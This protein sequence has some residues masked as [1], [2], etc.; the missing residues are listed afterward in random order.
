MGFSA[1]EPQTSN[2]SALFKKLKGIIY[3]RPTLTSAVGW[4]ITPII[5]GLAFGGW[6]EEYFRRPHYM[7]V[8]VVVMMVAG[9]IAYFNRSAIYAEFR[10]IP[11]RLR[12]LEW[13]W[14]LVFVAIGLRFLFLQVVPPEFPGFEE[15]QQGKI[16]NDIVNQNASLSFHFL[17]SNSLAAL[18]FW[19]RGNELA[20]L[21]W[22]FEIAGA[23]SILLMA[24]CLRQFGMGWPATL[25]V[26]FIM[27]TLRW[28]V[29]VGG[30]A[31]ETFGPAILLTLMLLLMV[32]SD[33][34]SSFGRLWAACCGVVCGILMYEYTSYVFF[35]PLPAVYWLISSVASNSYS[36]R[37]K[38][39]FRGF[40]FIATFAVI[41]APIVTQLITK[42]DVTHVGDALLRHNVYQTQ[43]DTGL[44]DAVQTSYREIHGY[45]SLIFGLNS[46]LA[47][48][49]F[50]PSNDSVVPF[51]VGLVFAFG[52]ANSLRRPREVLPF[53]LA[54]AS[55]LFVFLVA[56]ASNTYYEARM[57]PLL[58]VLIF[59][60]GL[61]FQRLAVFWS[62]QRSARFL[63]VEM[64]S[65]AFI[66]I[67]VWTNYQGALR[68]SADEG[69]LTEYARG[70]YAVCEPISEQPY[71][72]K[73]VVGLTEFDCEF[74]DEVWLYPNLSF[75]WERVADLP[76]ASQ[77][78]PGTLVLVGRSLG[79]PD[80]LKI[81]AEAL[82]RD[83]GDENTLLEFKTLLDRTATVT[84]CHKCGPK[85]E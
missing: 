26:A 81:G 13:P 40:W 60:A 38:A 23:I 57:T 9:V 53:V 72:F 75:E 3:R 73:K 58:P 76:I 14:L 84:F 34:S 78:D 21:R 77:V 11:S 24:I 33:S 74:N 8:V 65:T 27:A 35:V 2:P 62:E 28:A 54:A 63:N 80:V 51:I 47:S 25:I 12:T 30:L 48:A 55:L 52:I 67:V 16:A 6:L 85:I 42:P 56:S 39:L 49:Y 64:I 69:V 61:M 59:L 43:L 50:R 66:V 79:L 10:S 20:D 29:I 46:D 19:I 82:A 71:A 15:M 4:A 45:F 70:S 36:G 17:F 31:E 41:I 37:R 32:L 7:G 83:L 22:G 5:A 44:K 18:G 68:L 1:L